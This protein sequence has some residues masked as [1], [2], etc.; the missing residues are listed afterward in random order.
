MRVYLS[1][2]AMVLQSETGKLESLCPLCKAMFFN[3]LSC[4]VS[5]S[6]VLAIFPL[7]VLCLVMVTITD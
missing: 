7:C 2:P 3:S 4:G 6:K 5:H 1:C